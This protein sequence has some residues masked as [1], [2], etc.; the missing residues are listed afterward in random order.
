MLHFSR[1]P[2][3]IFHLILSLGCSNVVA[4]LPEASSHKNAAEKNWV[5]SVFQQLTL[6]QK[7]A[8]LIMIR[9]HSDKGP[10]HIA[11]VE[12]LIQ[13]Y[14]VGGLCFFQ[15]T[16]GKQITLLNQYQKI[17]KIPLLVGIDGEWSLGM[18]LKET[19][20]FPR[21]LM[22]GA[23]QNNDLIYKMGR[24]IG[25]QMK[26]VGVHVNFAPVAD[27][28]NNAANPVINTRS[29][30]ED[31]D[32][33]TQKCVAYMKGMQDEGIL[34]CAK[35][36]P[37]HGD[38]NV[39]S[40]Y[41]LPIISHTKSRLDSIELY[42]FK[43]LAKQGIASFMVA[44]LNIPALDNRPNRP[45][46]L[47]HSIITGIARGEM[48]F[49]GLIFTDAMEMKGVTKYFEKGQA[50]AEA[51]VA[52]NDILLLPEDVQAAIT[53]I[54]K[55][56]AE[57]TLP[58][59]QLEASVKRVLS[60]KYKVGL[61]EFKPIS[62][63]GLYKDLHKPSA[64][65]NR[66]QLIKEAITLVRNEK[67]LL[68][69]KK[70]DTLSLA[71]LSIGAESLT[72]FQKRLSSYGKIENF[73]V[74]KEISA[75]QQNNLLAK[76]SGR[77][78]VIVGL[79]DMN[80]FSAKNFGFTSS[81]L[82]FLKRL[83]EKTTLV[84]VV[85]GS[86]Y[87]LI[88]FEEIPV[89]VN[90]YEGDSLTQDLSAQALFGVFGLKGKLP[91]SVTKTI[92]FGDGI[93]TKGGMRMGYSSPELHKMSPD[94]LGNLKSIL[95]NAI[96]VGATPGGV[97][98][99]AKNGDIIFEEAFGNQDYS[100]NKSVQ[101]DDIY[102]LASI[103]KVAATTLAIMRLEEQG[104]IETEK[105]LS[106]Y[107]PALLETNKKDITIADIMAHR[108]GLQNWIPFFEKTL[109]SRKPPVLNEK[110]YQTTS[111]PEF[112]IPVTE[113]IYLRTDYRDSVLNEIYT[114]AL[115]KPNRYQ[116]S[117]LGF[118][119][120]AEMVKIKTGQPLDE[121]V[122]DQFYI[123]LGL[124]STGFNPWKWADLDKV[125]P[126]EVDNY[127]RGQKLHGYVHDM[128]S[129]MLGGVSGHAGLFSNAHD[130]AILMQVILY[131]GEYGGISFFKPETIQKFTSHHPKSIR[132]GIGWDMQQPNTPT[133]HMSSKASY[134]TFGH[135]GFTGPV[136]W[137]DP[138]ENLIFVFL[139]NRTFPTM[140]NGLLTRLYTRRLLHG[141]VYKSLEF[142]QNDLE[143][144]SLQISALG[145]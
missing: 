36:F 85:F 82:A 136:V 77:E 21:Q 28:N 17:S 16:P 81:E 76:L 60:A 90:A 45:S 84:L 66:A 89:I 35:H 31:R 64:L 14:E 12:E 129:A 112:S 47:S 106:E 116:Y 115:D 132:R 26:R 133:T 29:F 137:S 5:D 15:G 6:K 144:P 8:Q 118:Y 110:Y 140:R 27:V 103:T 74:G 121:Y 93:N 10:D 83:N 61:H 88:H 125:A 48:N 135:T 9:A 70:L 18:R 94:T 68:P 23:V 73:Q 131:K 127:F 92:L 128:G 97:V 46:T 119:L 124:S 30:G 141:M 130:L 108:A 79:H 145:N 13:K 120:L 55:Y 102:D 122:R 62:L 98:L 33:V 111:S 3:F 49:D 67:N 138:K 69:F 113:S 54:E 126:S 20:S 40:H 32:N 37:G 52:G 22:L 63:E 1:A 104:I 59:T 143:N 34:A 139:S 25:Q 51:L 19:M 44:H 95:Q 96:E 71:S 53:L 2:L 11:Q 99:V 7:I 78:C 65:S 41:D 91:V 134:Q 87:S 4:Q 101:T 72:P 123:P 75:E 80:A 38:T 86:P 43:E 42:P 50:E 117:D 109:T 114:S 100:G 24:E 107:L 142:P 56:L 39:D 57:G 58:L 105:P